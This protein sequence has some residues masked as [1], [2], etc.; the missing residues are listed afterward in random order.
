MLFW[1][2]SPVSPGGKD[3]ASHNRRRAF[4]ANFTD[5]VLTCGVLAVDVIIRLD[6]IY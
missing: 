1:L 6:F 2:P 4:D 3:T 5:S